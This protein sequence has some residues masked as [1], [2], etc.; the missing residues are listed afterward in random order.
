MT[1]WPRTLLWRS[2]LLIAFLL[3]LAHFAWLQIFQ[4]SEREPR[5]RQIA[6]QIVS[7]V[8]LTRAALITADPSKRLELLRDLSQEEQVQVYHAEPDERI[9]PL[10]DSPFLKLIERELH[11]MLG[12]DTKFAVTREGVPGV[13]VSFT[14]DGDP[15][16]VR[17]PRTRIERQQSMRWI[18]WGIFVLALALLGALLVVFR[19]NRP[20]SQLTRA[21]QAMGRGKVPAPVP[22]TGPSEISTLARAFNQMAADLKRLD[23][24]RALLLAGVSHDLRTPLSRIRLG[25]EM[26][27]EQA[28]PALKA[29]IES[30][31]EDIDAAIN[32]FLDFARINDGEAV[33]VDGDLN[34]IVHSVCER[35]ANTGKNVAA[36]L[37]TLPPL[38][39]RP[40]AVQR[41]VVNLIENALRHAGPDVEVATALENG[42]AVVEVR[43]RGPGIPPE[44]VEHMLQPFTRLNAARSGAGTGLGLAIVD[45]IARLHGGEVKL[46]P[47]EGGGLR[48]RVQ[49]PLPRQGA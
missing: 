48:A 32:Q 13:W 12:A 39:L 42:Y 31:I 21:A 25:L 38:P 6:R 37:E 33:V 24:E 28:D 46:L 20:L 16:W 4:V 1:L 29:G 40:T 49:F 5:A 35:Y 26:L 10:P 7:I 3:A 44:N 27:Q 34:A 8:N 11:R 47:R 41:M 45:R 18:G 23:D 19:V 43:D 17:I 36:R 9:A 2:V 14:I 15:F 22:E 30:D